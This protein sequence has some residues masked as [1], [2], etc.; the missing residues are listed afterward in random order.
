VHRAKQSSSSNG[1]LAFHPTGEHETVTS[2]WST[3]VNKVDKDFTPETTDLPEATQVF[4]GKINPFV[5]FK[6]LMLNALSPESNLTDA[7]QSAFPALATANPTKTY[8]VMFGM[9]NSWS[10]VGEV[11]KR[12]KEN[13]ATGM[14]NLSLDDDE[15]SG[16]LA[17]GSNNQN[18]E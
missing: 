7:S 10:Y 4:L 14:A 3:L 13:V 5:D 2:L 15:R 8:L 1:H 6:V 18:G 9:P 17:G 12:N 16:K 11:S